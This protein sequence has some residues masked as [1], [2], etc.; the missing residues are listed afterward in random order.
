MEIALAGLTIIT[1]LVSASKQKSAFEAAAQ[2]SREMAQRNA[3]RQEAETQEKVRQLEEEK[4]QQASLA[5][6]QAGAS[7]TLVDSATNVKYGASLE[8]AKQKEIDWAKKAG[9]SQTDILLAEGDLAAQTAQ[10][11]GSAA[12]WGTAG[13]SLTNAFSFF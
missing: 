1:G 3:Q 4:K 6:A 12:W 5:L 2:Q 8:E 7:G 13:S 10:A 9:K 11:Q